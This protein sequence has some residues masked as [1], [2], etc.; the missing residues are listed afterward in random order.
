[1]VV[2][3]Q[4]TAIP[5]KDYRSNSQKKSE[6]LTGLNG[7]DDEVLDES[8]DDLRNVIFVVHV[9]IPSGVEILD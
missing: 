5:Y 4:Q 7:T 3:I 1:M 6:V 8:E 9:T 2:A